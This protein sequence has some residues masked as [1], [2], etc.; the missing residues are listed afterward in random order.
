MV[1]VLPQIITSRK[2]RWEENH[3]KYVLENDYGL[4]PLQ[5]GYSWFKQTQT[6]T[7]IHPVNPIKSLDD[8]ENQIRRIPN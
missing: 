4:L 5:F 6:S 2:K 8:P 1:R 3:N 7:L